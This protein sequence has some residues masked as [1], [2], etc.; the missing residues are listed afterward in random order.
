MS[1]SNPYLQVGLRFCE[2]C[3]MFMGNL[4]KRD[5][6]RTGHFCKE[7]DEAY[8]RPLLLKSVSTKKDCG[9]HTS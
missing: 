3:G 8:S 1:A 2:V 6:D 4:S 7:C 5:W 9:I